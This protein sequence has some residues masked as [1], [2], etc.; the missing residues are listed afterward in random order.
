MVV[1]EAADVEAL[2]VVVAGV[3][4]SAV[5]AV[6]HREGAAVASE[7]GGAVLAVAEALAEEEEAAV[8]SAAEDGVEVASAEEDDRDDDDDTPGFRHA[9]F[10]PPLPVVVLFI[11][12]SYG[13]CGTGNRRSG[14]VHLLALPTVFVRRG[15][16]FKKNSKGA[17]YSHLRSICSS[18]CIV[19]TGCYS[20]QKRNEK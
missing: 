9:S 19:T 10:P 7:A 8:V 12:L 14:S 13:P 15:A 11:T 17:L 20:H 6:D 2:F 4:A 1:A 5:D 16:H 3:V 18:C